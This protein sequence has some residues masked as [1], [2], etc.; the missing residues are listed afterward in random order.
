MSKDY[1]PPNKRIG[2]LKGLTAFTPLIFSIYHLIIVINLPVFDYERFLGR[3]IR[4]LEGR[5]F[6]RRIIDGFSGLIWQQMTP[7]RIAQQNIFWDQFWAVVYL[8]ISLIF[9]WAVLNWGQAK[10]I[11]YGFSVI[12]FGVMYH[13]LPV[14]IFPDFIPVAGSLDDLII[15]IFATAIGVSLMGEAKGK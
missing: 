8:V 11:L 10:Y 1:D 13:F 3:A 2:L 7:D 4:E 12:G 14:D 6:L 9:A 15:V 5:G